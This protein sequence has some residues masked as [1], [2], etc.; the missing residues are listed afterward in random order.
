[1]PNSGATIGIGRDDRVR[2]LTHVFIMAVAPSQEQPISKGQGNPVLQRT[3]PAIRLPGS[4]RIILALPRARD[5]IAR[6]LIE[7]GGSSLPHASKGC[8]VVVHDVDADGRTQARLVVRPADFGNH[9]MD[10]FASLVRD[11][12]ERGPHYRFKPEAGAVVPEYNCA[13]PLGG[14]VP[15]AMW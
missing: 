12:R 2:D 10:R 8:P 7:A 9:V 14:L 6:G 5:Q 1:M 13:R 11:I 15:L 4:R 3:D